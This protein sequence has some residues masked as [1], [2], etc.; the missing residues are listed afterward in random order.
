MTISVINLLILLFS[1]E[2]GNKNPSLLSVNPGLIIWTIVIFILLLILLKKIA[3]TPLINALNNRENMIK[4][5]LE[6]VEKQRMEKERLMEENKKIIEEAN[7]QAK[8]IILNS[9][10][11]AER[12]KQ[13][14]INKANQESQKILKKANEEIEL[15]RESMLETIKQDIISIAIKAAEKII[16]DNLNEKKHKK[17][18]DEFISNLPK[19]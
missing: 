18:I 3:W 4:S 15:Q 9:K 17:L 2:G 8:K 11:T 6:N 19:N 14:I 1:P 7:L 16:E 5:S 10:E 13:D 12:L